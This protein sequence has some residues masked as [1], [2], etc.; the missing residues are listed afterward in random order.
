MVTNHVIT[1]SCNSY[2]IEIV[3]YKLQ[4][5][6]QMALPVFRQVSLADVFCLKSMS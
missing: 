4:Y 3:M 6:S 5:W 1:T 2:Q